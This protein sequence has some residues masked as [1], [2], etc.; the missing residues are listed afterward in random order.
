M[1]AE[2]FPSDLLHVDCL[3]V[4]VTDPCDRRCA[5]CLH[6][7]ATTSEEP[8]AW[9]DHDE[10]ARLIG[11]LVRL[12]VGK[13]RLTGGEPL[14]RRGLVDLVGR[15]AAVS[16]LSELT[17][18]TNG[19]RLASCARDLKLAGLTDVSI[20]P[21]SLNPDCFA[22]LTGRDGIRQ[23][24]D[25]ILAARRAGFVSMQTNIVLLP[26]RN[27]GH[28]ESLADFVLHEGLA[29]R[30]IEPMPP[31][32]IAQ[33]VPRIDLPTLVETLAAGHGLL[34]CGVAEGRATASVWI[35]PTSGASLEVMSYRMPRVRERSSHLLLTTDGTLCQCSQSGACLKLGAMLRTG[36]SDARL[37]GAIRSAFG[38][39]AKAVP[40]RET[41]PKIAGFLA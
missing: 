4:A 41:A 26:G 13:V 23:V 20:S 6:E 38:R 22:R 34:P 35:N 37:A 7:E 27:P 15:L 14:L 16:G 24:R 31:G 10:T 30:L 33:D 9:L 39:S 18:S 11:L 29:L 19:S 21:H 1:L 36:A 17:L 28:L 12:G 25:G 32:V 2:M 5:S 40:A 3:R 8:T